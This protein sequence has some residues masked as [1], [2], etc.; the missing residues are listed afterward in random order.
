LGNLDSFLGSQKPTQ[1]ASRPDGVEWFAAVQ[2][3]LCSEPVYEQMLFP[4]ECTL[5]WTCSKGHRS[6][7]ENY[8]SF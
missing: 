2:C 3:Q 1:G 8:N 5:V 6:I 7:I 4:A